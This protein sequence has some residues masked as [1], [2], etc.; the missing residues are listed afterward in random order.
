MSF[1]KL[2]V[3]ENA[4]QLA[5]DVF[6]VSKSFPKEETYSLTDQ[7]RRASRSICANIVEAYR[8]RTYPRFFSSKIRGADAETSEMLVW[9]DF[10]KDC[11]Y[12]SSEVH[13]SLGERYKEI[14]RMLGSM[15]THPERFIPRE[16]VG[17][18]Q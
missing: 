9:I 5:M 3:Y 4:Y 2:K 11:G 12:I 6:K 10:A 15:A 18:N 17:S 7:M 16:V 8:E 1:K 14:G 13:Q